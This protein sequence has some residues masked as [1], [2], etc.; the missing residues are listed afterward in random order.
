VE[1]PVWLCVKDGAN[2]SFREQRRFEVKR[3]FAFQQETSAI[4][5]FKM[6][7]KCEIRPDAVPLAAVMV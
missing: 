2:G 4:L 5:N 6:A 7:E 1:A 3:P